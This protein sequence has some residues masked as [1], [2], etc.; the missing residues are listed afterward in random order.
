MDGWPQWLLSI[1]V[2]SV[3]S[4]RPIE[5]LPLP[6]FSITACSSIHHCSAIICF[7]R[8]INGPVPL[9][10]WGNG[11]IHASG[12]VELYIGEDVVDESSVLI[13]FFG[14]RET[15]LNVDG[16]ARRYMEALVNLGQARSISPWTKGI[17]C[18][19]REV[20]LACWLVLP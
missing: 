13:G 10:T 7:T 12:I 4:N 6:L 15:R 9:S 2:K 20:E 17:V 8:E 3:D 11:C 16:T 14:R 5:Y 19:N 1:N 18:R